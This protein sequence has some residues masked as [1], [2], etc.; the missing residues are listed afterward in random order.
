M[1]CPAAACDRCKPDVGATV[2]S[3]TL[4]GTLSALQR[5]HCQHNDNDEDYDLRDYD[6][7]NDYCHHDDDGDDDYKH[8]DGGDYN[9]DCYDYAGTTT[10][11]TTTTCVR[12]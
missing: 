6:N 2:G 10:A 3:A 9:C 4:V 5:R 1:D 8:N 7:E 11:N 12:R